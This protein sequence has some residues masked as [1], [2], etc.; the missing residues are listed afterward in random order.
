M[1]QVGDE[2]KRQCWQVRKRDRTLCVSLEGRQPLLPLCCFRLQSGPPLQLPHPSGAEPNL[3][4]SCVV[5]SG[6][7]L[8]KIT[9]GQNRLL[10]PTVDS[11]GLNGKPLLLLRLDLRPI[12]IPPL[13]QRHSP[14][15]VSSVVF[16]CEPAT[17]EHTD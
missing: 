7:H 9:S 4:C 6:N 13:N 2:V 12:E 11:D 5:T 1:V 15:H 8:I 14:F 10:F 3:G 16:N 17:S